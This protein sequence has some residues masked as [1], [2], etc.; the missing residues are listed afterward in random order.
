MCPCPC[1]YLPD[2][3]LFVFYIGII[4][5]VEGCRHEREGWRGN[6]LELDEQ[7]GGQE[8][9]QQ[10]GQTDDMMRGDTRRERGG[11]KRRDERGEGRML[12]E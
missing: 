8:G 12:T 11:I 3:C 5:E 6:L 1:F 9:G 7:R 2:S 10:G 4:S